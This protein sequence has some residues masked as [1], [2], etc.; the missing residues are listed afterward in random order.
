MIAVDSSSFIAYWE[1]RVGNDIE[2]IAAASAA[3]ILVFPA[4]V[5]TELCSKRQGASHDLLSVIEDIGPMP[6]D[7]RLWQRAGLLRASILR[8]GLKCGTPDA[9]IAQQ[10]LDAKISIISRD[11]DF[12]HFAEAAGLEVFG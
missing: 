3:K 9:L 5:I 1:G 11:A 10:C 8:R 6:V 7:D 4:V 2:R 12:R